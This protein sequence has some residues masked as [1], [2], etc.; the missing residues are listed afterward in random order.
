MHGDL[1]TSFGQKLRGEPVK[2][3]G[4]TMHPDPQ[5]GS[6]KHDDPNLTAEMKA[7]LPK[8]WEFTDRRAGSPTEG[9]SLY[10]KQGASKQEIEAAIAKKSKDVMIAQSAQR[11]ALR[12]ELGMN[13]KDVDRLLAAKTPFQRGVAI[14]KALQE[15]GIQVHVIENTPEG[16]RQAISEALEQAKQTVQ[17]I[18]GKEVSLKPGPGEDKSIMYQLESDLATAPLDTLLRHPNNKAVF[19]LLSKIGARA[20][21]EQGIE[22]S[23]LTPEGEVALGF[24]V[25]KDRANKLNAAM[26][27]EDTQAHELAHIFLRDMINSDDPLA[28]R[29][30]ALFGGS[31]EQLVKALGTRMTELAH[32]R[33]EGLTF[34]RFKE[35]IKDL[36]A[37]IHAR[38]KN[39][40]A[41]DFKRLLA[42]RIMRGDYVPA[43]IV[44]TD[45]NEIAY[46]TL[47]NKQQDDR[48]SLEAALAARSVSVEHGMP[49]IRSVVDRIRREVNA[50]LGDALGKVEEEARLFRGRFTNRA[51]A[52]VE[53]LSAADQK[54]ALRYAYEMVDTKGRPSFEPSAKVLDWWEKSYRPFLRDVVAGH[55]E[56]GKKI[57]ED[58]EG[59]EIF[60]VPWYTPQMMRED[61][62]ELLANHPNDPKAIHYK[63]LIVDHIAKTK[64]IS[65]EAAAG[66]WTSLGRAEHIGNREGM[67]DYGP[68]SRAAGI[69]LPPEVR[70]NDLNRLVTRYGNR[71]ATALAWHKHVV[72]DQKAGYLAGEPDQFGDPHKRPEDL[73]PKADPYGRVPI[74]A[75]AI[76]I[77]KG[78]FSPSDRFF[79]SFSRM[80]KVM[81]MQTLTGTADLVT[82]WAQTLPYIHP[83]RIGNLVTA[84]FNVAKGIRDGLAMGV[85]QKHSMQMQSAMQA[86]ETKGVNRWIT[87]FNKLADLINTITGRDG[88]ER[89]TRGLTMIVGEMEAT[90]NIAHAFNPAASKGMREHAWKFLDQFAEKD[91][92]KS[93][94]DIVKSGQ[95][96]PDEVIQRI[97]ANMVDV[98]QGTYGIRGL[99][100]TALKGEVSPFLS[101]AKWNIEKANN[102]EKHV[103]GPLKKGDITPLLMTTVGGLLGGSAV[104]QLREWMTKRKGAQP[105]W[106]EIAE[107]G[108]K[109]WMYKAMA[110]SSFSGYGGIITELAKQGMDAV[111]GR[112]VTGFRFP[113][114]AFIQDTAERGSQAFHAVKQGENLLETFGVEFPLQ[115]LKDHVQMARIGLAWGDSADIEKSNALRDLR[116]FRELRGIPTTRWSGGGKNPF[117]NPLERDFEQTTDPAQAAQMAGQLRQQAIERSGGDRER[118]RSLM[119]SY[120]APSVDVMPSIRSNP[121]QFRQYLEWVRQT[122]GEEA[123]QQ[124]LQQYIAKERMDRMKMAL[125]PSLGAR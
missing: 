104:E 122:Q 32:M 30:L 11:L 96:V 47:A 56:V 46:Q 3:S 38:G 107:A 95:P 7:G 89:V 59:R 9:T 98:A 108:G 44:V 94:G 63:S 99:P 12:S 90:A 36:V 31:E 118:M 27:A 100:L 109:G 62:H 45:P 74:V 80:V 34:K 123:A 14:Y 92:A 33:V 73:D 66:I 15:R 84:Y 55:R 57:I 52:G 16:H 119:N 82:W 88:L 50:Y 115:L 48:E 79:D 111:E 110:L 53:T 114:I 113:A 112:P 25:F 24:T 35:W 8:T 106:E 65:K 101:L 19:D 81:M 10:V 21:I 75:E 102:F 77:L 39:G 69:G 29:G 42:R 86:G 37:A 105:T 78:D 83:S 40:T 76:K 6:F 17:K 93:I 121:Q 58:G 125:V 117:L 51:Q 22:P 28:M 23:L 60:E 91:W 71:A 43:R 49:G 41:E 67:L 72:G 1:E 13:A 120:R 68:L 5:Y 103:I 70:E 124:L 85:I 18:L 116:T 54:E 64:G 26:I 61:I 4:W 87:R 97:A 20:G 2:I